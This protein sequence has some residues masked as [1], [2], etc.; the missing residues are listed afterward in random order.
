MID[1]HNDLLTAKNLSYNEKIKILK[2]YE[3]NGVEVFCALF[4][5]GKGEEYLNTLSWAKYYPYLSIEDIGGIEN[6]DSI[7]PYNPAFT[8]L[9]WNYNNKY[10]GGAL[11]N[12]RLT[13]L[14]KDVIGVLNSKN[15]ALDLSHLNRKTFENVTK[16]ANRI[17]VSHTCCDKIRSHKRN[18]TDEQ[19]K[20]V[21]EKN[22]IV[23][24][25]FY[26]NFLTY[27]QKATIDDLVEHIDYFC[28]KFS[29]KNLAIGTDFYGADNFVDGIEDYVDCYKIEERLKQLG[30]GN[31]IINAIMSENAQRFLGI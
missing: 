11:D 12:G 2:E 25:C 23:G 13:N 18:L 1:L 21:I 30:Y 17:L 28:S 7:L 5:G 26:S 20:V 27:N 6:I 4:L 24:L 16:S 29:Y 3:K 15:I 22:G 14:G 9:T 10:G 31:K 8:T 19:I